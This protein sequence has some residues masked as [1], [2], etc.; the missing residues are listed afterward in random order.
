LSAHMQLQDVRDALDAGAAGYV[1]KADRPE[2]LMR[3]LEEGS[4]G[5]PYL[6]PPI[7]S[8]LAGA[9]ARAMGS[10][11]DVLSAR[12]REIFRLFAEC[13]TAAEIARDL[14]LARKT[15]DTHLNRINRKLRLRHRAELVRLA[16]SVGLVHSLRDLPSAMS[17]SN[18]HRS[19]TACQS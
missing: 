9:T 1:L 2:T 15:V 12:E 8:A 4:R 14:C 11:L 18:A 7:A 10:V 3:A 13:L 17:G 6:A 5:R 19:C 16:V